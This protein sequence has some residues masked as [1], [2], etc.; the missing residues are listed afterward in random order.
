M[1]IKI[2]AVDD[3]ENNLLALQVAL[4]DCNYETHAVLSGEQAVG[5][6]QENDYAAILLDVQMPIMDGFETAMILRSEQ[7]SKNT[8]IIFVTAIRPSERQEKLGCIA[9]AV[10]FLFKPISVEI[11]EAKLGAFGD[12]FYTNLEN[13][14]QAQ[15][16]NEASFQRQ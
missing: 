10:D 1:K 13:R 3:R 12:L 7:R 15:L 8:P 4:Q 2:L 9:G 14:R 6:A 5:L 11:L 16:F